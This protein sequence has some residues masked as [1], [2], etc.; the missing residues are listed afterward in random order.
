MNFIRLAVRFFWLVMM[1]YTYTV[2]GQNTSNSCLE[3]H[4]DISKFVVKHAGVEEAC[5]NCHIS[6]AGNH[7][8]DEGKEFSLVEQG[9][10]LC[11]LCHEQKNTKKLVHSPVTNG[12]CWMCHSPHGSPYGALLTVDPVDK[13]C[14][15]CHESEIPKTDFIHAPVKSGK[16]T[17]CH[18]AHESDNEALLKVE[19]PQ[20]CLNC[21]EKE[22]NLLKSKS[23]HY[24]FNENCSNCHMSH[25]SSEAYLLTQKRPEL[26]FNCH[27]DMEESLKN[28]KTKH[29]VLTDPKSCM[30][31]H[32][33]HASSNNKL[34]LKEGNDLCYG[35]HNK[36]VNSDS[37][38]IKNISLLVKN[39]KSIHAP[40]EIDGCV[41][42]HNPHYSE[43]DALLT[44]NYS[45]DAYVDMS[46][47][48][49]ELCF[50]CHDSIS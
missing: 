46:V 47:E 49:N 44:G 41:S 11:Y 36:V 3:C 20:L 4:G 32:N 43:Y 9:Q 40:I 7:P 19:K 8:K 33:P 2:Q 22:S 17:E 39:G 6:N 38:S 24:P 42:C 26:C 15:R 29:S 45:Q 25:N 28:L 50:T 37:K 16:C 13:I 10:S 34:L 23:V 31:C 27:G 35:C 12:Y 48:K 30:N 1:F 18:D 21:H 5:D 14:K